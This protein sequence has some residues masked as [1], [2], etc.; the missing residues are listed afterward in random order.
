MNSPREIEVEV[1]EPRLNTFSQEPRYDD[2]VAS[3][4]VREVEFR[5]NTNRDRALDLGPMLQ[6]ASQ[7][8]LQAI[9]SGSPNTVQPAAQALPQG[10]SQE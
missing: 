10:L 6:H 9:P 5:P 2:M 3:G 7:P 1:V 8:N 4:T